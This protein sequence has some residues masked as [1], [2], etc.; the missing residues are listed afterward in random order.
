[1]RRALSQLGYSV[2]EAANGNEALEIWKYQRYVIQLLLTDMVMPGGI[3]GKELAE[4]M[5]K[6]NPKLKVIYSSGYTAEVSES[7]FP[8]RK[9]SISSTNLTRPTSSR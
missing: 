8:W 1:V 4:R 7:D 3:S 9:A 2:L 6:E 5:L